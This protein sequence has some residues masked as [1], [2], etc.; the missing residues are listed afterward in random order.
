MIHFA[1]KLSEIRD[2]G[3]ANTVRLTARG[4]ANTVA[5]LR[6]PGWKSPVYIRRHYVDRAVLFQTL[7]ERQ[8][9]HEILR[10][11]HPRMIVD[12]GA[13]IG[14]STLFFAN[15]FPD[16]R[17]IAIEPDPSN[18]EILRMNTANYPNVE[19]VQAA[20][21]HIEE[22]LAISNPSAPNWSF[23]INS[24]NKGD[25]TALT[26]DSLI[27]E[28]GQIDLLKLD[29]EG[30]EKQI[31]SCDVDTW[32]PRVRVLCV[33]LHDRAVPGCTQAVYSQLVKRKFQ[34]YTSGEVDVICLDSTI[35]SLIPD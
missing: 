35:D 12:A 19:P 1:E 33:E 20:L 2:W 32:L 28:Y 3:F 29:I 13:H 26:M 14:I 30:A 25:V 17:I 4:R 18:F 16:A 11:C 7:R 21:W 15:M 34:R 27:R 22:K 31:F 6:I 24:A 10:R 23:Q 8:Y 5:A 9:D